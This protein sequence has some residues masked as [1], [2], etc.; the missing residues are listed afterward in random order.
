MAGIID[1]VSRRIRRPD[2]EV[3]DEFIGLSHESAGEAHDMAGSPWADDGVYVSPTQITAGDKVDIEYS[4]LLAKSGAEHITLRMGYGHDRWSGVCDIPMSKVR[5]MTFKAS[6]EIPLEQCSRLQF[7]FVD[8]AGNWDNNS[9]RN[10]SYE[11]HCGEQAKF[12]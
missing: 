12:R 8:N 7:C 2:V 3:S 9:G 10:W 11:I 4:G 1:W 6:V 5:D